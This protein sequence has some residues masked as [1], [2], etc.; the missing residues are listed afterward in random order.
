MPD[1]NA[2]INFEG[3]FIKPDENEFIPYA[4]PAAYMLANPAAFAKKPLFNLF[5]P[6]EL[7]AAQL[8]NLFHGLLQGYI[9]G[10]PPFADYE[11]AGIKSENIP[12]KKAYGL[13]SLSETHGVKAFEGLKRII[14]TYYKKTLLTPGECAAVIAAFYQGLGA[15]N[16]EWD[17]REAKIPVEKLSRFSVEDYN[18]T[19]PL[20]KRMEELSAETDIIKESLLCFLIHGS[21]ATLDYIF[22]SSDCDTLM[23]LNAESAQSPGRIME[24]RESAARMRR[25]FIGVDPFQHHGVYAYTEQDMA[26]FPQSWLPLA[27]F[28][29]S[30][31][32]FAAPVEFVYK[33]RSSII[34]RRGDLFNITCGMRNELVAGNFPQDIL[35]LKFYLQVVLLM[36]VFYY[37][38]HGAFLYKKYIYNLLKSELP[39]RLYRLI[40]KATL[41]RN[42]NY[43]LKAA[44]EE[45]NEPDVD[46]IYSGDIRNRKIPAWLMAEAGGGMLGEA[47][48]LI[49]FLF[50]KEKNN[51]A[52]VKS[53]WEDEMLHLPQSAGGKGDLWA[54]FI[55]EL[56]TK[57]KIIMTQDEKD[58]E[59]Q[60]YSEPVFYDYPV[61]YDFR[62]YEEVKR[63]F[64]EKLSEYHG[65]KSV[66]QMGSVSAPGISDIDFIVVINDEFSGHSFM[67]ILNDFYSLPD[68]EK[69][70]IKHPVSAFVT[71]ELFLKITWLHPTFKLIKL[72]GRQILPGEPEQ[73]PPLIQLINLTD[74]FLMEFPIEFLEELN[75]GK[76]SVR[77]HLMRM[78]SLSLSAKIIEM[79]GFALPEKLSAFIAKA[80]GLFN[81]WFAKPD[82]SGRL[83]KE[84]L[85]ET[86]GALYEMV[87]VLRG[88]LIKA[89]VKINSAER[90]AGI[91]AGKT[92]FINDWSRETASYLSNRLLNGHGKACA[93]LP[94]EFLYG[95]YRYS[96]ET[97]ELGARIN[98][99]F[100]LNMRGT[101]P[102]CRELEERALF[103]NGHY[104]MV[105][106]M[107]LPGGMFYPYHF[108]PDYW[109]PYII[110]NYWKNEIKNRITRGEEF[111][112]NFMSAVFD[113]WKELTVIAGDTES[114]EG[115]LVKLYFA[116]GFYPAEGGLRWIKRQARF[117]A[118][119]NY[120]VDIS[121]RVENLAA[122]FYEKYPLEVEFHVDGQ[123]LARGVFIEGGQS[124][125]IFLT[126]G[127]EAE[128]HEIL[129]KASSSFVP[130]ERGLYN[131]SRELS[132]FLKDFSVTVYDKKGGELSEDDIPVEEANETPE[133]DN[134]IELAE[135]FISARELFKAKKILSGILNREPENIDALNDMAVISILEE[136]FEDAEKLIELILLLDPENLTAKENLDYIRERNPGGAAVAEAAK[137]KSVYE[138]KLEEEIRQY[139]NQEVVHNLPQVHFVYTGKVLKP[140]LRQITGFES[141]WDWCPNEI[142]KLAVKLSRK[143]KCLSIGCGN[144]DT[145]V[146]IL[147]KVKNKELVEFTGIDINPAMVGRGNRLAVQNG[148]DMLKFETGDFN[149]LRLFKNY[150]FIFANHS[151]H[152]V[153]NLENLFETIAAHSTDDMIFMI[154]DMIGRNG[155]VLWP[156]TARVVDMVWRQ[157]KE[158]YKFNNYTKRY[159][160]NYI[161]HDCSLE[162]FEGI[163]AEDILPLLIKYFDCEAY[164]PFSSMINRF[165]DRV[166]GPNFDAENDADMAIMTKI[167]DLDI[168]LLE[169]KKLSATQAQLKMRKKG[170]GNGLKYA[171]QSPSETIELRTHIPGSEDYYILL[172]AE[173]PESPA[174]GMDGEYLNRLI[175][176]KINNREYEGA[177]AIIEKIINADPEN[178]AAIMNLNRLNEALNNQKTETG[179]DNSIE[180]KT[181]E[182]PPGKARPVTKNF[183]NYE[184]GHYYSPIPDMEEIIKNAGRIFDFTKRSVKGVRL[185]DFKQLEMLDLFAKYDSEIPYPVEKND[186]F[187]YYFENEFYSYGDAVIN[188]AMMRHFNPKRIIE[189]GSGFSSACMLDTS[190]NYLNGKVQFTF[191]EPYADRLKSLLR[192]EDKHRH[193][194]IEAPVQSVAPEEFEVLS[195]NDILFIDSS[196]VVKTGSDVEYILTEILPVL[197]KGVIV[198]FH[199]IH[200]PFEYPKEW[201][202]EGRAWNEM[203]FIK[204]FLQYNDTFSILYFNSYMQRV[205]DKQVREKTP[206]FCKNCGG[207]IWL[208]KDK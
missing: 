165:I 206:L 42:E 201:V 40:E 64:V 22:E 62:L 122:K 52:I 143:I 157:L 169:G 187:R 70:V 37:Q 5:A 96:K 36:P 144:G 73:A 183:L 18:S 125:E 19:P 49:E 149:N 163:R 23:I 109:T 198:H 89:G 7:A 177:L 48:E 39:E 102:A 57:G 9:N 69:Y 128:I 78:K 184:P 35:A 194:I 207:G 8:Q 85:A 29:Y 30:K 190:D 93:V 186:D 174:A 116:E 158:K 108:C 33:I 28:D 6:D 195:E 66:Y 208:R 171:Y 114:F 200:Y 130:K 191:I 129:I 76:I 140:A 38:L 120:A 97:G 150:D 152:H 134:E 16:N 17:T 15:C 1:K 10:Y 60:N 79:N 77:N 164:I 118:A 133:L 99:M 95:I 170:R 189:V 67:Q 131:D 82:E 112:E 41:F 159:D 132:V 92:Y 204:A 193:R 147:K 34:E 72:W 90:I 168:K 106:D 74:L 113:K 11:N 32:L 110:T 61:F 80:V 25:I 121:F 58:T 68:N 43:Y 154:N 117:F 161:N 44:L 145:E 151:L 98:R 178:K 182:F 196:H 100:Y 205:Y 56:S 2:Y 71:E 65:V 86:T 107:E 176:E 63:K 27:L 180:I 83:F 153:V 88:C 21:M 160:D 148:F 24:L 119:S 156:G 175:T 105:E 142:D 47:V 75:S 181:E 54:S 87:S 172:E 197:R 20:K 55:S 91:F 26:F 127:G 53:K 12:L 135:D 167:I 188:F 115:G 123:I 4:D 126:L 137:G 45:E 124:N 202:Y 103:I 50:E 46:K 199:D 141:F 203:Y 59:M 84:L 162:G 138:K 14:E 104:K 146:E 173:K 166:Y 179:P 51:Y 94:A 139:E 101:S 155:H 13:I 136:E 3:K 81:N 185:N 192:V 111:T 31:I